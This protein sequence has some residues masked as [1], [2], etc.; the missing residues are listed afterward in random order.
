VG[1]NMGGKTA[2]MQL[3]GLCQVLAQ[4][5]LP[6]PAERFCTRLF[7]CVRWGPGPDGPEIDGLSAFGR[8][9]A[10]LC[11]IWRETAAAEPALVFMDEPGRT[12][13][14]RE[15]EALAV[16]WVEAF[17]RRGRARV[18]GVVA[19]HFGRVMSIPGMSIHRIRGVDPG[20]LREDEEPGDRVRRL[21]GAVDYRIER[22]DAADVP[23][24]GIAVATWLGAPD[25]VVAAAR[26]VLRR[27]ED[28]AGVD[29]GGECGTEPAAGAAGAGRGGE[30][31]TGRAADETRPDGPCGRG[32]GRGNVEEGDQ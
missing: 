10:R 7:G 20:R 22:C 25:E 8:E 26:A 12:T 16:A 9:V 28:G 29:Q 32:T 5:A 19:T 2:A 4:H 18:T 30:C 27:A 1:M 6:V 15:G 13:N 11:A 3:L 14:P 21:R 31:G 23:E 24:E 17:H